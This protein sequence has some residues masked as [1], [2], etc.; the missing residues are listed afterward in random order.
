MPL[1]LIG[2]FASRKVDKFLERGIVERL[3]VNSSLF[4]SDPKLSRLQEQ[5]GKQF[6]VAHIP[7]RVRNN[8]IELIDFS[9]NKCVHLS[10]EWVDHLNSFDEI[11][12]HEISSHGASFS[13]KC[14]SL[15]NKYFDR[16]KIIFSGGVNS[17]AD[18][19][20]IMQYSFSAI[21]V[22]NSILYDERRL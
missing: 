9:Q 5:F 22:D 4:S 13:R 21:L 16:K 19:T 17:S 1:T 6:L 12:I 15:L 3:G 11:S 20:E 7:I 8:E 2:G 18:I 10:E 14:C